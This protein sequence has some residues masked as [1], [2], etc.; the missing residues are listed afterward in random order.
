[1]SSPHPLKNDLLLV[2]V[3]L[4]AASGWM[5]SRLALDHMP[6]LY[7]LG[8]RFLMAGSVLTLLGLKQMRQLNAR[9]WGHAS[10]MG[11][12]FGV[13]MMI[14][15]LGLKHS[16][17]VGEGAFISS[18]GVVLVPLIARFVFGEVPP[19]ATWVALPIALSGLGLLS[20][21]NGIRLETGQLLL[22]LSAVL[23]ALH[24]NLIR[25][26]VAQVPALTFTAIQLLMVGV[27]SGLG[28]LTLETAPTHLPALG[29]LW[30]L[31][32][33][34][35]ASSARFLLQNHAQSRVSA[36]HAAVIMVLEPVWASLLAGL[37]LHESM[38]PL[39]LGGCSLI[40]MAL[41]VNRWRAVIHLLR[42]R[43]H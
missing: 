11:A 16:A 17:H 36:S 22:L 39:Q 25:R 4:L 18:L 13:A 29:W 19:L 26:V 30:I 21:N 27:L 35:I 43:G 6:P 12:L 33:A 7:F 20:L 9:Q 3:T 41:L 28:S 31:L 10:A 2:L 40:F 24:F 34:L 8:L 14:W 38:S 15:I 1:M 37:F 32:A 23:F 5:F 42:R